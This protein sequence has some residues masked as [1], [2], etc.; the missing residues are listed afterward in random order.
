MKRRVRRGAENRREGRKEGSG[1][2]FLEKE[3]T[4][5]KDI[6]IQIIT[7]RPSAPLRPL[8]SILWFQQLRTGPSQLN[9]YCKGTQVMAPKK[10]STPE[11]SRQIIVRLTIGTHRAL[12]IR[13]AE[14]D[15]SIQQWVNG[16]IERELGLSESSKKRTAKK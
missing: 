15:T 14:E 3:I 2:N 9:N 4:H 13:V 8:R 10:V 5:T 7:L 1:S 11:T 6:S 12:R 16:L